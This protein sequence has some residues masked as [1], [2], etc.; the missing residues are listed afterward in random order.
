MSLSLQ[1]FFSLFKS[2][3]WVAVASGANYPAFEHMG[4]VLHEVR[5]HCLKDYYSVVQYNYIKGKI[6]RLHNTLQVSNLD[7]NKEQARSPNS[8]AVANGLRNL[9]IQGMHNTK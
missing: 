4:P 5:F 3:Q 9:T 7:S 1:F 8:L 6:Q 2:S